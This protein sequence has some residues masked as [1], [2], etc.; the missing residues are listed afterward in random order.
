MTRHNDGNGT[1]QRQGRGRAA[2][3]SRGSLGRIPA[4][5]W[6]WIAATAVLASGVMVIGALASGGWT[7]A[8][9][10]ATPVGGKPGFPSPTPLP[11]ATPGTP[12]T[13]VRCPAD[14]ATCAIG[15]KILRMFQASDAEGVLGNSRETVHNCPPDSGATP[16]FVCRGH[17][18]ETRA[19]FSVARYGS[20]GI[21]FVTR[22]EF[23]DAL[24][25]RLQPDAGS[26]Y[27]LAAV[28]CSQPSS[29]DAASCDRLFALTVVGLAAGEEKSVSVLLFRRATPGA[30]PDL[31]AL[32]NWAPFSNAVHGGVDGLALVGTGE[33]ST[34]MLFKPWNLTL[35][36]ASSP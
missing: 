12:Y 3:L 33:V 17:A 21:A 2:H 1:R 16:T 35:T 18:G 7:P 5:R 14:E 36:K 29:T 8:A 32:Y 28:G 25:R 34:T 24:A 11:T 27:V 6:L 4:S 15:E 19:G 26:T 13:Q 31:V 22:Q 9:N 10:Q 20:G 30:S 23:K